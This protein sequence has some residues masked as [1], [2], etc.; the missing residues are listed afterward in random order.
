MTAAVS[1]V[2]VAVAPNIGD[3][4]STDYICSRIGTLFSAQ[5]D[6]KGHDD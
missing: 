1:A 3:C 6:E 2:M 5:D 4:G